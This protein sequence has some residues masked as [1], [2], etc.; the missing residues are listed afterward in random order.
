MFRID[1]FLGKDGIENLLVFR[2][3]NSLL[4]P[5]WN[6]NFI[7][8]I[9]ITMAEDFGTAG[10]AK[11]YDT[12]GGDPRRGAEPPLGDRG[13]AGH[14]AAG[15]GRRRRPPR[16]EGQAVP[17]DPDLR[18]QPRSS[19]ASTATTSTSPAWRR[20]PT[21][22]RSWPCSFE[23][24][25]WR[26]AGVPW[27]IRAGKNLPVTATEAVDRV[28]PT[29][30][31]A[32]RPG[33]THRRLT[34]TTSGSGWAGRAGSSC[35]STPRRRATAASPSRRPRGH[36]GRAVRRLATSPTSACSRT[37]WRATP[38]ASAA[39]TASTSSGASSR[40]VLDHPPR[41]TSTSRAPGDR[42]EAEALAAPYG[43]WHEPRP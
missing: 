16:R 38:A 11:F 18:S 9:Q 42:A 21:P 43:G 29:A 30:A 14:G 8:S 27:L 3:A 15:G 40:G 31:D 20:A 34:R 24:E 5:V 28:R 33:R 32:L 12:A 13:P 4:E 22:R 10:R 6:R 35:S 41:C 2:F 39:T 17:P 26:W 23:I 25:S 36:G 19:G 1:H 37:P 7:S